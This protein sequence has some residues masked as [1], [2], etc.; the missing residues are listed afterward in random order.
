[1]DSCCWLNFI[2][3]QEKCFPGVDGQKHR[4]NEDKSETLLSDQPVNVTEE[5][6]SANTGGSISLSSHLKADAIFFHWEF[7]IH[8][9]R[10]IPNGPAP[11]QESVAILQRVCSVVHANKGQKA[12]LEYLHVMRR[13]KSAGFSL[14]W[15]LADTYLKLRLYK[16]KYL[17]TESPW[18]T[19]G[20][21][22]E[23]RTRPLNILATTFPTVYVL[24]L[25]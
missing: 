14:W 1:M 2:I 8:K 25:Y 24:I 19:L 17:A 21:G 5:D 10:I 18:Y 20:K 9:K 4:A 22:T 15:Q 6:R 23:K 11:V 16:D 12:P 13:V 3:S 7:K